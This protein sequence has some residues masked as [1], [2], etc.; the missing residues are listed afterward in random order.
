MGLL[1][2]KERVISTGSGRLVRRLS[3]PLY[4]TIVSGTDGARFASV[5]ASEQESL[6]GVATYVAEQAARQLWPPSA[7]QVQELLT[8]GDATAA[9]AEYFHHAG[10]RWDREWLVTT[11]LEPNPHSTAWSSTVP[12]PELARF[13]GASLRR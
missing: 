6:A 2:P 5:A 3:A 1:T 10:E 4:V 12:L 7:L 11:S 13:A 8:A 9:V